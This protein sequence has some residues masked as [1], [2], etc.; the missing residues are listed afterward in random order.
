MIVTVRLAI[1][2]RPLPDE[3]LLSWLDEVAVCFGLPRGRA[4]HEV[5]LHMAGEQPRPLSS[6]MVHVPAEVVARVAERT[7]L[8]PDE[9]LAMT[10]HGYRNARWNNAEVDLR[11][12]I[13]SPS[14]NACTACLTENGNR[15]LLAWRAALVYSCPIHHRYLVSR[16][17]CGR[18]LHIASRDAGRSRFRC[19][20]RRQGD[21]P[22][23]EVCGRPVVELPD[24]PVDDQQ[25]LADQQRVVDLFDG[26][27]DAAQARRLLKEVMWTARLVA[28]V[29]VVELLDGADE[30]VRQAFAEFCRARAAGGLARTSRSLIT[31]AR[32]NCLTMAAVVGQAARIVFADNPEEPV[33]RFCAIIEANVPHIN[34][35]TLWQSRSNDASRLTAVFARHG[36]LDRP[37]D[38]TEPDRQAGYTG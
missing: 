35:Y 23:L 19:A 9:I 25:V 38:P 29:G 34:P 22:D 4:A 18:P 13:S 15:W 20:R 6:L 2:P 12:W 24:V 8:L 30:P 33:S 7:G 11:N 36:L 3:S 17:A 10:F 31:A 26:G 14:S 27:D 16:C 5:G 21:R 32:E 1:C 28:E 37:D